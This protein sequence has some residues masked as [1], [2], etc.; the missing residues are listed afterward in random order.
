MGILDTYSAYK[1]RDIWRDDTNSWPEDFILSVNDVLA[2]DLLDQWLESHSDAEYR[3][4][5]REI[6]EDET[7]G[8]ED[9]D[10][11]EMLDF[12]PHKEN[13]GQMRLFE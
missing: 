6:V 2:S 10:G 12:N 11:N 9:E 1:V 4:R 13:S 3:E 5:V 8:Y 7:Y